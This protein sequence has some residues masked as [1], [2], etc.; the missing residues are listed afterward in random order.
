MQ[1]QGEGAE[2]NSRPS[3]SVT[4]VAG[5]LCK[6][7]SAAIK[8]SD[9]QQRNKTAPQ[10]RLCSLMMRIY[11]DAVAGP[12]VRSPATLYR[13]VFAEAQKQNVNAVGVL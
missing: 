13:H 9:A 8:R 3:S 7:A 1:R 10:R 12:L 4:T 6:S 2:S 5:G 11:I